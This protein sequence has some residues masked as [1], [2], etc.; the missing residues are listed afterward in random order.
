MR[1]VRRAGAMLNLAKNLLQIVNLMLRRTLNKIAKSPVG[2]IFLRLKEIYDILDRRGRQM[3][4]IT[5]I[6][7]I[8]MNLMG[9]IAFGGMAG[10]L[11]ILSKPQIITDNRYISMIYDLLGFES[12]S[13]FLVLASGLLLLFVA[14]HQI[15]AIFANLI[16]IRLLEG[17]ARRLTI[18]L[19]RYFLAEDYE[20][21]IKRGTADMIWKGVS[22]GKGVILGEINKIS[23]FLSAVINIA[24]IIGVLYAVH[25]QALFLLILSGAGFYVFFFL[26]HKNKIEILG[27]KTYKQSMRRVEMIKE[28]GSA[29]GEI[30]MMGKERDF[31][32]AMNKELI[33]EMQR[34][35]KEATIGAIPAPSVRIAAMIALYIISTYV[36][37]QD[38]PENAFASLTLF[39]AGAFRL[40]PFMQGIFSLFMSHAHS[41]YRYKSVMDDLKAAKRFIERQNDE[42]ETFKLVR[43]KNEITFDNVS[44]SY[45]GTDKPAISNLS[46]SFPANKA[47]A[48]FGR[49]GAGK[50][51][52]I[53]LMSGILSPQGGRVLVDGKSLQEDETFKRNWQRSTGMTFQKPFFM[54]ASVAMNVAFEATE[55][56]VD[57]ERVQKAVKLAQLEDFVESLPDGLNTNVEE[58][59][60]ILSG[61]QRQRIAIARA[62]Y[63]ESSILILDEATNALDLVVEKKIIQ[64]LIQVRTG[65]MIIIIA[66]RPETMRFADVVLVLKEDGTA[67]Q[68]SYDELIERDADF[69]ALAGTPDLLAS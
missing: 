54:N 41:A 20:A 28:G 24:V 67:V 58:D 31:T 11:I 47:I 38:S 1:R 56:K 39:A 5:Q 68:G 65:R 64:S 40:L 44:Y 12:Q 23:S 42:D 30:K 43:V 32:H 50:S 10:F 9:T 7:Q 4:A 59:A 17:I 49:S 26:A 22:A 63:R 60:E 19:Y 6:N 14:V 29:A 3:L 45:P 33:V 21:R 57:Y 62:L 15:A 13:H 16:K 2:E 55:E 25:P 53:R 27:E 61:G 51:T 69:Q 48:L 18:M 37:L 8:V 46:F 36:F 52:I 34:K 66:H 35:M